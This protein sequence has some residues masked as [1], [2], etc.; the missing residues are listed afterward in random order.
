MKWVQ[1][2]ME[3][4]CWQGGACFCLCVFVCVTVMIMSVCV[5]VCVCAQIYLSGI[6]NESAC[7]MREAQ[8]QRGDTNPFISLV[9]FVMICPWHCFG[10]HQGHLCILLSPKTRQHSRS[11]CFEE[12]NTI[13]CQHRLV[14][15]LD[16]YL[17][18]HGKRMWKVK[19]VM[20]AGLKS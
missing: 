3:S 18:V 4:G 5:S 12:W 15:W 11:V 16:L 7:V 19:M 1:R 20:T 9:T 2:A 10:P 13:R 8:E 14:Y 17:Q 6:I